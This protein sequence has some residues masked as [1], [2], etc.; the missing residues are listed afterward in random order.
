MATKKNLL[1]VLLISIILIVS[2]CSVS[3]EA[4]ELKNTI[5]GN[6]QLQSVVTEGI[7]G[8]FKAT[9]FNEEDFNCFIG[10]TWHFEKHS[11][12]GYYRID[13]N[14]NECAAIQRNIRWSIFE[15]K[16]QPRLVQF[17]RLDNAGKELDGGNGY[18]FTVVSM[19]DKELKL[20]N[21]MQ[22]EG[23]AVSF[24]YKFVRL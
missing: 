5:N 1:S 10:S 8:R 21:D 7:N 13:Q 9:I 19:T 17:K 15:A 14:Q 2:S 4:R 12:T 16:D 20:R 22:F 11:G 24:T 6:W 3:K 18:R 23:K